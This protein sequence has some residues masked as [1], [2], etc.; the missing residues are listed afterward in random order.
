MLGV[1]KRGKHNKK[2]E[3]SGGEAAALSAPEKFLHKKSLGQNF[4]TSDF[5]PKK[6]CDAAALTPGETVLEIGPG[7][8]ALT[9]ELLARGVNVIAIEADIR[10]VDS[11]KETFAAEISSG[12]L[13]LRHADIKTVDLQS[14]GLQAHQYKVVANIPYYLSGLLFRTF[15]ETD[16]QPNTLVFLVQKEVAERIARDK[17]ESLLSISIKVFGEPSYVCTVKRGHFNPAPNVDS[18]IIAI[19]N[20]SNERLQDLNSAAFF[21]LLHLGFGQKRKQLIHNLSLKYERVDIERI[22]SNLE[23]SQTVRAEDVSVEKWLQIAIQLL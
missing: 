5:I 15:L 23:L 22:L 11:L 9:K 3:K 19:A 6:M 16:T 10:A 20:I 8:G 1:M 4:L 14:L 17:K 2:D 7:T 12:E 13:T 21:E 18:A